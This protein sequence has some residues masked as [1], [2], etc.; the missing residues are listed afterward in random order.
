[1]AA[2][3]WTRTEDKMFEES[4]VIFPETLPDRWERI[5]EKLRKSPAEVREHYEALVHDVSEIDSGR[6]EMPDY[7]DDSAASWD[8]APAQ[9]SFRA[10]HGDTEKKKGTPWTENEHKL[11]LIGLK[12]YGKGDWRSISRNV[13]VTRTPTQVAS[14]AQKYFLRQ[15][16]MKKERK[17]SSIHD[18]TITTVDNNNN[19]NMVA[20]MSG[21]EWTWSAQPESA[22]EQSPLPQLPQSD[23]HG[24]AQ[25]PRDQ[26]FRFP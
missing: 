18:I 22:Q 4:L 5:A 21:P 14:H 10:K 9:I 12:K 19:N 17:R 23:F 11:F 6:V 3:Q 25:F 20:A 24:Q 16:S 8:S 15:T 2:N 13:V 1:M 26:S 7:V